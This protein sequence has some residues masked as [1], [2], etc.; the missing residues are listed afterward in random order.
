[1]LVGGAWSFGWTALVAIGTL[2]LAVVTSAVAVLALRALRL[3]RRGLETAEEGLRAS[4]LP[5]LE[6]VPPY[7]GKHKKVTA[8][9]IDYTSLGGPAGDRWAWPYAVD[10]L[11][12][13]SGV[14]CS[15]PV[16]NVGPGVARIATDVAARALS[17]PDE[18]WSTGEPTRGLIPPG[19]RTRVH[20]RLPGVRDE[21]YVEVDYSDTSDAQRRRLRLYLARSVG[22]DG[23][24]VFH[25]LGAAT[26]RLTAAGALL[27]A[28]AGD[29]RVTRRAP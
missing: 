25:V 9:R 13:E 16:R 28:A 1:M 11:A 29:E 12:L 10:V 27:F 26:Y 23:D 22:A 4:L 20:F 2:A 8:D 6:P 7:T 5:V 18:W 15:I 21:L 14:F 3:A 17:V 24:S 19:E